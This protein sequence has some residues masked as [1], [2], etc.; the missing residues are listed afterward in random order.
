MRV[1]RP[2]WGDKAQAVTDQRD[3]LSLFGPWH[4]AHGKDAST[5]K[6]VRQFAGFG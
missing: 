3:R 4:P 1:L 6:S 5:T 2:F